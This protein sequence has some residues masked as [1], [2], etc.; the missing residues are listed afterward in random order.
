MTSEVGQGLKA[1][2]RVQIESMS[3]GELVLATYDV[4]IR[5]C[6]ENNIKLA[7]EAVTELMSG[8]DFTYE[9]VAGRLVV[10]YDWIYRQIKEG[11]LEDAAR[12]LSELREAWAKIMAQ[13]ATAT[14]PLAQGA[15]STA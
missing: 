3:P 7:G 6:R 2:R 9:E 4:A 10:M 1:Y 11:K 14:S 15:D 13:E 12:F 8:L 5:A